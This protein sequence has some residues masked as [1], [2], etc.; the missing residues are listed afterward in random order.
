M[1]CNKMGE[2]PNNITMA[3]LVRRQMDAES[4]SYM[5]YKEYSKGGINDQ[6]QQTGN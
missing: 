1:N 6:R 4:P 2:I 3:I 5:G